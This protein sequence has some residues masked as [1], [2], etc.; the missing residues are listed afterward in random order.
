MYFLRV[1]RFAFAR[2]LVLAGRKTVKLGV[3]ILPQEAPYRVFAESLMRNTE[4]IHRNMIR[5]APEAPRRLVVRVVLSEALLTYV[6]LDLMSTH[7]PG[8]VGDMSGLDDHIR[9][10]ARL[11]A[12]GMGFLS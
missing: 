4:G 7:V 5:P 1:V 3:L 6:L 12:A 11:G 2:W 10:F 9:I 8:P